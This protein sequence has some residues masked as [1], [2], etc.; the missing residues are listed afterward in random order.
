VRWFNI[1]D[2]NFTFDV[3]FAKEICRRLIELNLPNAGFGTPNGIRMS[4]GDLELWTLMK[5]AGW[6]HLIVAPESGSQHTLNLMKK[7]LQL[8]IVQEK[9]KEIR[10]AGLKVQAFFI[11]GYPGESAADI[12]ETF[13]L[14]RKCRFNFVFLANFQPLPGTP[15]YQD[16]VDRGEIPDGLLP[17]NFSDGLRTYT[18]PELRSFNFAKFFF[19]THLMMLFENPG[20]ASYHLSVVFRQYPLRVVLRKLAKT[21]WAL[22]RG[23]KSEVLPTRYWPQAMN[24]MAESLFKK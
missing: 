7:D 3:S 15:V 1:I 6:R 19:R 17:K 12:E 16:L 20:N 5:Q 23:S 22:L 9:V 24:F 4:R 21:L 10:R 11:V 14:I 13:R 2:D 18:P 8:G